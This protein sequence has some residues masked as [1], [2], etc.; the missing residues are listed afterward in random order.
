MAVENAFV[1]PPGES[2]RRSGA[3]QAFVAQ[4]LHMTMP[5]LDPTARVALADPEF[6]LSDFMRQPMTMGEATLAPYA[7]PTR[8]ARGSLRAW[9]MRL[10]RDVHRISR[11]VTTQ[12]ET[13][14][15]ANS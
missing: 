5:V 15:A 4:A 12:T 10:F 14:I 11:A 6:S 9:L 3:Y 7:G 1:G 13:A 8:D 2:V